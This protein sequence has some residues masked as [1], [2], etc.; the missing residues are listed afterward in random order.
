MQ[1]VGWCARRDRKITITP[2]NGSSFNTSFARAA[3]L[4]PPR[5]KSTGLAATTILALV[6]KLIMPE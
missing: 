6:G 3:R 2:A 5:R 1:N 4:S